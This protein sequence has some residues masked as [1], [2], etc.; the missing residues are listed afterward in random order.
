MFDVIGP[1]SAAVA[2]PHPK[3]RGRAALEG[4]RPECGQVERRTGGD[5][6][7]IPEMRQA[8]LGSARYPFGAQTPV[9]S[10]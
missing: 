6:L 3:Q 4:Q 10:R 2:A 8:L 9:I 1:L 7:A 5:E